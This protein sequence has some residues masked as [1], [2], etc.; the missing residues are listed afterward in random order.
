MNSRSNQTNSLFIQIKPKKAF[1]KPYQQ[2]IDEEKG[3]TEIFT[4]INE[5]N[6]N[7]NENENE[8]GLIKKFNNVESN[9]RINK[10]HSRISL[11]I[12]YL[13]EQSL[14]QIDEYRFKFQ[15][16]LQENK[17]LINYS[18][19][20]FIQNDFIKK[21]NS[22]YFINRRNSDKYNRNKL[23]EFNYENIFEYF[24]EYSHYI[25]KLLNEYLN[26]DYHDN[27]KLKINCLSL[28]EQIKD[29]FKK[30]NKRYRIIV[31]LYTYQHLDQSIVG[32]ETKCFLLITRVEKLPKAGFRE[33]LHWRGEKGSFS[34]MH[35]D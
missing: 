29:F 12:S 24:E 14:K 30:L 25:N 6:E 5:S 4:S 28:C 33:E 9:N 8:Y 7:E 1:N 15:N 19:K 20:S 34:W 35:R 13:I 17:S 10:T 3:K 27:I 2:N 32:P 11:N 18:Q 23:D 16:K 31:Q 26:D 22:N 21:V